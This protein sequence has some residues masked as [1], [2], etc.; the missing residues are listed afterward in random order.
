MKEGSTLALDLMPVCF[1]AKLGIEHLYLELAHRWG[2]G[3]RCEN[4]I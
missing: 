1:P 4:S 2:D 3:K